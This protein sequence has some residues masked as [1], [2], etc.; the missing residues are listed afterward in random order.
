MHVAI[1]FHPKKASQTPALREQNLIA[2][3]TL[4][5]DSHVSAIGEVGLDFS[6]SSHVWQDQEDLLNDLLPSEI[7]SKVLVLHCLGMGS[8][9]SVYAIR[10]LLSILQRNNIPEHQPINFHCFTGN[11]LM[12]MWLPVYYN[13]YFGFTRLVKTYNKS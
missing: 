13:T 10:H 7:D 1:G 9:D 6:E 2:F 8:G 5:Q 11:K 12:E 3:R 4:V